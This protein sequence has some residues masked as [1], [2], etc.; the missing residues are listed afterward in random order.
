M[1]FNCFIK[2][3]ASPSVPVV[4]FASLKIILEIFS[5]LAWVLFQLPLDLNR[6]IRKIKKPK[7]NFRLSRHL[8]YYY[9]I[10]KHFLFKTYFFYLTCNL[11]FTFCGLILKNNVFFSFTLLGILDRSQILQNVI[12]SITVNSK[13][14]IMTTVFG[15]I[16]I[17]IY[18]VIGFYSTNLQQTFEYIGNKDLPVCQSPLQCFAFI[19]DIGLRRGGGVGEA[20]STT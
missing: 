8:N 3:N 20:L 5:F 19:L 7:N 9:S 16:L 6:G 14:L 18:S 11:I 1:K 4:V 10:S 15:M 2:R 12:K 17:Y 13:Q